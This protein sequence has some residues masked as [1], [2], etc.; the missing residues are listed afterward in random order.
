MEQG[1]KVIIIKIKSKEKESFIGPME[2]HIQDNLKVID[3]K[4]KES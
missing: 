3:A 1:L 4:E 2:I